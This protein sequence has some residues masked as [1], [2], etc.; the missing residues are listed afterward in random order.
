MKKFLNLKKNIFIFSSLLVLLFFLSIWL[1]HQFQKEERLYFCDDKTIICDL[2]EAPYHDPSLPVEER[3]EDLLSH[4]TLDEKIGQLALVER[5][6]I[7]DKNDIATYGLGGLLSGAG[8]HP[9]NNTA[10]GWQEMT[11]DYQTY[12]KKTRLQIPLLYGADAIHGNSNVPGATVF[13]H[14]IGLGAANDPD[15]VRRINEATAKELAATGIYWNYA[16]SLDVAK[17]LRWGRTYET[18]SSESD[19]VENL[20]AAAIIG[21]QGENSATPFVIA[22]AKHYIGSGAMIW[23]TAVNED[24]KID[25]GEVRLTEEEL[26]AEHLPPFKKA[27]EAG[28][29]SVMAGLNNW[30]GLKLSANK[31]LLTDVLK[32]ELGFQGF[33]V[34]DWYGVYEIPGNNYQNTITAINAGVDMVM[35]PFDYKKFIAD[36]QQSTSN[37]RV[38][39]SRLDDAVRRILRAKFSLG[40]FDRP[41][42]TAND[43][44]IIGSEEHRA[45]AREAVR[46][47]LVLLKDRRQTLPLDKNLDTIIVAGSA[48]DNSG[49]QCGG[50]TVEWQG[51]DGNW[52]PG[53]S[54]ILKG[55]KEAV[56]SE[57]KVIFEETGN[58]DLD[59][60]ADVGIVIVGEKSYAEGVGDEA[61]PQLSPEDLATIEKVRKASN[62]LIVIIVSGR[63][64]NIKLPARNWD[65]IIAAW[66]PG[67]E[68]QGVADVLF[69]G[70]PFVGTLP[71]EWEL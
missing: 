18:F 70:Y 4:M 3:V 56:S 43:L 10:L 19:R 69:G 30:Q 28:V 39:A 44:A 35:L 27:V 62:K 54:S 61:E 9:E 71:I 40:L 8:S 68:G 5:S 26:R 47:S 16:P 37:G 66:L 32:E 13:P 57:T 17:D 25:Q 33:V 20:A 52:L 67:S 50:W 24:Y 45:L 60:K 63:P 58:F 11:A 15:L 59:V 65:T 55:I 51:I 12:T 42:P 36:L 38:P 1:W 21:L 46:K 7:K 64:L 34:S 31:Y 6:E 53:A 29:W 2:S 14:Q 22:T 23:G 48:A 41:A 49:R